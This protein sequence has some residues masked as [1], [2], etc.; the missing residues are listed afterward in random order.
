VLERRKPL[1]AKK[2]LKAD[3]AKIA[4]WQARSRK[5]A[6]TASKPLARSRAPKA[7]K[8]ARNDSPWRNEVM[9]RYGPACVACGTVR[10]VQADHLIPRGQ[11]GP[12]VVENG[13]PLC[14][15]FG[16]PGWKGCHPAKTDHELLIRKEWLAPEQVAWLEEHGHARWEKDGTV[17][18]RHCWLFAPETRR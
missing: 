9:Q 11:G 2:Q 1:Q 14:G 10:H 17:A 4:A 7:T 3:P 15:E 18:G 13:L 16:R 5:A 12:S 8:K 6:Q